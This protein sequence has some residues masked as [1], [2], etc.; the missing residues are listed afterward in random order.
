MKD[1]EEEQPL[2]EWKPILKL[3]GAYEA[4]ADGEIRNTKTKRIK[5]QCYD[6]RY[7]KFGYDYVFD[8]VRHR[9]WYRVHR[10]IAETFPP[11]VDGKKTVNHIDGDRK[12]NAVDNLEWASSKD[13]A[14]HSAQVLHNNCGENNYNAHFENVDI[15]V[16]K[17]MY[18]TGQKTISEI[19]KIFKASPKEIRRIVKRER[20]KY[21]I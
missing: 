2:A 14:I 13:Q 15:T 21:I 9:G 11:P 5:S 12:N 8:G 17:H 18:D 20:W 7:M 3:N 16:M 10:A 19:A 4:S 1:I 6:G